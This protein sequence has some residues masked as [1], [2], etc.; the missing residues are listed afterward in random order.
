MPLLPARPSLA[1]L[2]L[3]T[4]VDRELMKQLVAL[5]EANHKPAARKKGGKKK[6]AKE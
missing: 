3:T 5:V 2:K 6:G 1:V 4:R